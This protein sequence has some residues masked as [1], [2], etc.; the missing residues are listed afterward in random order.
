MAKVHLGERAANGVNYLA[1]SLFTLMCIFPFY[2]VI[3]YS[4]SDPAVA[5]RGVYLWPKKLS[6]ETY[7]GIFERR[8]LLGAYVISTAR[9]VVG[10][11][12]SVLCS[13]FLAYLVTKKE[14]IGR[15]A[16][17]RFVITTMYLSVGLI[18]WY[19]TMKAYGLRNNFLLYVVPGTINAFY[20]I[21]VKT[22]I[23]QLPSS[24]E[25]SAAIE[26]A[27]V[28][29]IF[30][31]IIMPLSKP[32]VAT[33]TVY[34]AVAQWNAWTDNFFLV[35]VP[36]LQT[37]QMILYTYL[38]S[39]QALAETMRNAVIVGPERVPAITPQSVQMAVIVISVLPI[40]MVYPFLQKYFAKGIMLGAIKG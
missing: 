9:T 24:L 12:L 33:I 22:Y 5:A 13:S 7:R 28:F 34:C 29:T 26:G 20:L 3:I 11:F 30:F 10:T 38:N 21:L 23:E 31:R 14:M 27:G 16:V 19:L 39:A 18:P 32:I 17:Y 35:S 4:I 15:R 37:V 40:L 2:Y 8:D 25:E 1:I 36:Q 6:F